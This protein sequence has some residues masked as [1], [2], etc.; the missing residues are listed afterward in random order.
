V[1][2]LSLTARAASFTN[3]V[4]TAI[5]DGNP[6]GVS[7]TLDVS[8]LVG[9]ISKITVSLDTAGGW[10]GDLYAYLSYEG[11]FAV[12]LNRVGKTISDPLGYGDAGLVVTFDDSAGSDIHSYGGNGGNPLSGL[13]QPD[14]RNVNPQLALDSDPRNAGLGSF[15]GLA[16]DGR[17][18]LFMADMAGGFSSQFVGW[19]LDIE[20]VPEPSSGACF[21]AGL[22]LLTALRRL[23]R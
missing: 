5:P 8:G 7:S 17:W 22:V 19:G 10:N 21:L 14:G 3:F 16:P 11:G 6:N 20:T 23:R 1:G 13:W 9:T 2:W 18:T 12:L 15:D 4:N